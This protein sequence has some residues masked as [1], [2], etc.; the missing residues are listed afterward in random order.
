M[1]TKFKGDNLAEAGPV[2]LKKWTTTSEGTGY[3]PNEVA[4]A[5]SY[6]QYDGWEKLVYGTIMRRDKGM[7]KGCRPRSRTSRPYSR[8]ELFPQRRRQRLITDRVENSQRHV[9]PGRIGP[10]L[11]YQSAT[12]I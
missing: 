6:Q 8:A 4:E 1:G 5:F 9:S 3:V 7:I 11:V 12:G 2:T 10:R